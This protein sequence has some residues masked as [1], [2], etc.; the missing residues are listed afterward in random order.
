M[1]MSMCVEYVPNTRSRDCPSIIEL[2]KR[3]YDRYT[4][5]R[6]GISGWYIVL[7]T[8]SAS[9]HLAARLVAL[10]SYE[11]YLCIW[12]DGLK[13]LT[14]FRALVVNIPPLL[15]W[16]ATITFLAFYIR[17]RRCDCQ[18]AAIGPFPSPEKKG[19]ISPTPSR[20]SGSR[21]RSRS[22]STITILVITLIHALVV[23]T[24]AILL[25]HDSVQMTPISLDLGQGFIGLIL[26]AIFV[27]MG[28]ITSLVVAIP[29]VRLM[30]AR[31]RADLVP[32][33]GAV[34]LSVS[35][36][37]ARSYHSRWWQSHR[38]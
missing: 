37:R 12:S 34:S 6:T 3:K 25:L 14:A 32:D 16:I 19:G 15:H 26:T 5:T 11:L 18:C 36:W 24:P 23:L 33:H 28:L 7:L 10:D 2:T 38:A 21:S 17:F 27:A 13:G 29:Q 9:S 31:A 30:R 22:P 8:V 35:G 4:S 1:A 20:D